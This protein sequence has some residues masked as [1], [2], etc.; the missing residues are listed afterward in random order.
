MSNYKFKKELVYEGVKVS[1]YVT[2][3]IE[4]KNNALVFLDSEDDPH[5]TCSVNLDINLKSDEVLIKDYSEN[6]GMLDFLISN[7]IVSNPINAVE[8]GYVTIPVC[9]I[10]FDEFEEVDEF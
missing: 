4:P 6:K 1:C 7:N 8:S 10:N 9:K 3:Y 5:A 2:Q